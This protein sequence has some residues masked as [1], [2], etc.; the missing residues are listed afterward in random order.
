MLECIEEAFDAV[1]FGVQ[2]DVTRAWVFEM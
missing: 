2:R 1:A